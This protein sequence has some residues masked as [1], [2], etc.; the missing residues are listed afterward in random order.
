M[1]KSTKSKLSILKSLF[2]EKIKQGNVSNVLIF[3]EDAEVR[4]RFIYFYTIEA[5]EKGVFA[6]F[7]NKFKL[8]KEIYKSKR[9]AYSK[10]PDFR[11]FMTY[12]I[13]KD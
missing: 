8:T 10:M 6:R 1:L 3:C 13:E 12:Y 9:K 5:L 4:E 7:D 2:H 11:T